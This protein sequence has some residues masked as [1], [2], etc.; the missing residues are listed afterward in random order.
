MRPGIQTGFKHEELRKYGCYFFTLC[1][2]AHLAFGKQFSDDFIIQKFEEYKKR[3]FRDKNGRA[4]PWIGDKSFLNN[5]VL[6]FND[7]AGRPGYFKNAEHTGFIPATRRFPVFFQGSIPHFA[8]GQIE[9]GKVQIIFD[10]WD[11]P[12]LRRGMAVTNFRSFA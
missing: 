11:P 12:A 6:I 10:S 7:L 1:A 9:N 8:L 2:W 5:P 4:V 3:T